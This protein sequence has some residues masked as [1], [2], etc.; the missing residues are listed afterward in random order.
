MANWADSNDESVAKLVPGQHCV[1]A[2]RKLTTRNPS[3]Y[4]E[5]TVVR[6]CVLDTASDSVCRVFAAM[7]SK[8]ELPQLMTKCLQRAQ[9]KLETISAC[10]ER[11]VSRDD[12]HAWVLPALKTAFACNDG[13]PRSEDAAVAAIEAFALELA[14]LPALFDGGESLLSCDGKRALGDFLLREEYRPSQLDPSGKAQVR[15]NVH[16]SIH[17]FKSHLKLFL[18]DSVAPATHQQEQQ[19]VRSCGAGGP[20]TTRTER[21]LQRQRARRNPEYAL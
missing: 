19:A 14:R 6:V 20:L 13:Q 9:A 21:L 11:R 15:S 10:F 3:L 5:L 2:L 18:H 1:A 4:L 7:A 8:Q 17:E 12:V 16:R